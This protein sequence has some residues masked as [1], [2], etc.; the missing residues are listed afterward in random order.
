MDTQP[1]TKIKIKLKFQAIEY[2]YNDQVI[3]LKEIEMLIVADEIGRANNISFS[4]AMDT[5]SLRLLSGSLGFTLPSEDNQ[6]KRYSFEMKT[7]CIMNNADMMMPHI[8]AQDIKA[9]MNSANTILFDLSNYTFTGEE[10]IS[11]E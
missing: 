5:T 6:N 10:T 4:T 9:L 1:G 8:A 3:E 7:D 2:P 11:K